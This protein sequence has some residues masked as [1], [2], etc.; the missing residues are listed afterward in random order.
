ML[1]KKGEFCERRS[2]RWCEDNIHDY[3]GRKE[4]NFALQFCDPSHWENLN[5]FCVFFCKDYNDG[6]FV[7]L[8]EISSL[9]SAFSHHFQFF[10]FIVPTGIVIVWIRTYDITINSRNETKS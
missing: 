8:L 2:H 10:I 4:K 1:M 7:K 3:E 9:R 5:Y 6:L